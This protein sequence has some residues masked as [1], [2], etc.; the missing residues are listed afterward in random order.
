MT[1]GVSPG[2]TPGPV[3]FGPV[4]DGDVDTGVVVDDVP[5]G[6]TDLDGVGVGSPLPPEQ[7]HSTINATADPPTQRSMA[8][9]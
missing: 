4:G 7:P 5:T 8:K 6:S 2:R 9:S 3:V 1:G